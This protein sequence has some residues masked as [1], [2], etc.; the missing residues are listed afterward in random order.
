M[1]CALSSFW[2]LNIIKKASTK[3]VRIPTNKDMNMLGSGSHSSILVPTKYPET[4]PK[5]IIVMKPKPNIIVKWLSC[6]ACRFSISPLFSK[7]AIF[8]VSSLYFLRSTTSL[9][10]LTVA[11]FSF[12]RYARCS[13]VSGFI[14]FCSMSVV[15]EVSLKFMTSSADFIIWIIPVFGSFILMPL[16]GLTRPALIPIL[17][18]WS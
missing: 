10:R 6:L 16:S 2:I 7:P 4:K 1:A 13:A 8:A 3:S 11:A 14:L 18:M 17:H 12:S 5:N 9:Q 15:F